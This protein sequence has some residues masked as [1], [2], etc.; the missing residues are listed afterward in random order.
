VNEVEGEEIHRESLAGMEE[1][2]EQ[3]EGGR[4]LWC[5]FAIVGE[6]EERREEE[7]EKM[8]IETWPLPSGEEEW[9]LKFAILL[10]SKSDQRERA[11]PAERNHRVKES[12]GGKVEGDLVGIHRLSNG[13]KVRRKGLSEE[14]GNSFL[15]KF[16]ES[17][18]LQ[19][20]IPKVPIFF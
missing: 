7:I 2:E 5:N 4:T 1:Q 14:A 9:C 12:N 13:E 3:E 15:P 10:E 18:N 17:T 16:P 19:I 20:F 8:D 6:E 11:S